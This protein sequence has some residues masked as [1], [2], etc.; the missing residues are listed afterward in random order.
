MDKIL[1]REWKDPSK[2]FL[3]MSL[4]DISYFFDEELKTAI[5]KKLNKSEEELLDR[6]SERARGESY[7]RLRKE[8]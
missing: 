5:I 7:T 6:L 4:M 2:V 8:L 3:V 1:Y